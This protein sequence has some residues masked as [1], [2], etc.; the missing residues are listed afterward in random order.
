M[1]FASGGGVVDEG[2]GESGRGV[3]SWWSVGAVEELVVVR[4]DSDRFCATAHCSVSFSSFSS[5]V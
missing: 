4:G 2:A 3:G 5:C 1:D